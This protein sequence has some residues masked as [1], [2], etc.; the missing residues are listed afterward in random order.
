MLL[1]AEKKRDSMTAML[2]QSQAMLRTNEVV[3]DYVNI[4]AP[5]TG[6]VVKRLVAPG[7][8][9][10]PGMAI[11]KITQI[12][13]VRL[14]ANV[15]EKDLASIKVGSPVTVATIGAG[16]PPLGA[17]VTSVFPFVEPGART[18]VVEAVVE[19]AGRRFLPGQYVQMQ[20]VTGERPDAL[21]V[22]RSAVARLGGKATVWVV[23]DDRADPVEVTTGLED[24]ERTEIVKGLEGGE[25]VIARGHEGLYAGARVSDMAAPATKRPEGDEHKG[26]PGMKEEP[27][28]AAP[29]PGPKETQGHGTG[30]A[31]DAKVAQ[32]PAPAREAGNLRIN[33][34]TVP[35]RP[36][37]GDT[38]LRVEVKDA[39]GAP[40][41]GAVVEVAAGMPGMAGPKI[42]ARAA[43]ER[44]IYEAMVNLGM[45]GAYTVDVVV[46][47]PQGGTTSAKFNFEA[48]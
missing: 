21:S 25:R 7:V 45:A 14:Q 42:A 4:R 29:A 32:A 23:K 39:A 44:G 9:V 17:R 6:Y 1:S 26:M 33:L 40:V 18:A 30:H 46:T 38:R 22:P 10:Q 3:R 28:R 36:R 2:A 12:D 47:R 19:N 13:K 31:A 37:V 35:A 41:S 5:S 24:P 11:L 16:A 20:F 34:S 8:L 48:K 15:G 43:K 27:S